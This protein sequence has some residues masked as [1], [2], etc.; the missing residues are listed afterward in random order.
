LRECTLENAGCKRR[1]VDGR[2]NHIGSFRKVEW[3]KSNQVSGKSSKSA[4]CSRGILIHVVAADVAEVGRVGQNL[5]KSSLTNRAK[6]INFER[7]NRLN[8]V[9]RQS[10][11]ICM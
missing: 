8:C 9:A 4:D 10:E 1:A 11:I 3:K 2:K 6:S 5:D 7:E